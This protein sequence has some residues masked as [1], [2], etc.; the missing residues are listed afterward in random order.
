MEALKAILEHRSVRKYKPDPIPTDILL[1]IIEASLRGANT[2][3]MQLYSVVVT[4]DPQI[5][6]KLLPL[7]F[8]QIMVKEAPVLITFCV[9]IYR[10]SRW[11][12]LSDAEPAFDNFLMFMLATIDA[13]IVA[14]N[15]VVLAESF[16]LGTCYLGT[17]LYNAQE[18]AQVLNLPQGVFP[19]I[20]LTM[21]YPVELPAKT[22]R[23]PSSAVIHQ[24]TY[25]LPSD[26]EIKSYFAEK[27]NDPLYQQYVRENNLQNLAQVF[28]KVRYK[29]IDNIS[30][31]KKLLT[32]LL[33]MGFMNQ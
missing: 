5:K 8:N 26:D 6:E 17:T 27:E 14:Q 9:D 21:G 20:A 10:F 19:L 23:L 3:N 25:R 32:A 4:T 16:G 13:T 24:D 28:T 12:E 31:S 33:K 11:C 18:M 30:F 2:G 1:S 15:C 29:E 22:D 7:H